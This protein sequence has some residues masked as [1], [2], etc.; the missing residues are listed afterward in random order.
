MQGKLEIVPYPI[1]AKAAEF[2]RLQISIPKGFLATE[3]PQ[4]PEG[5]N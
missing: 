2:T 4:H 3:L 5:L 1:A